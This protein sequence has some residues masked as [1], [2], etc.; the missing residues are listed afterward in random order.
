MMMFQM[1]PGKLYK[2]KDMGLNAIAIDSIKYS[3]KYKYNVLYFHW[4][5]SPSVLQSKLLDGKYDPDV[6][7]EAIG[8]TQ[9]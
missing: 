5:T 7:E 1:K 3:D 9:V 8:E 6:W 2:Y 4:L